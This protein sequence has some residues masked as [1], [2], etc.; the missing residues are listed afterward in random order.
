[1][2]ETY[3]H[4]YPDVNHDLSFLKFSDPRAAAEWWAQPEKFGNCVWLLPQF[5]PIIFAP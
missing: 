5:E 4:F 2:G 1:M 3:P